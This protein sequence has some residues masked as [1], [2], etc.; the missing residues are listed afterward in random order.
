MKLSFRVKSDASSQVL[1]EIL[2]AAQSLSQVF[3]RSRAIVNAVRELAGVIVQREQ[4]L[5]NAPLS[6][7]LSQY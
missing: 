4:R 5:W 1:K 7:H 6:A 3:G 2:D